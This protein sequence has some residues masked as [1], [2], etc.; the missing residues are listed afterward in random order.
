MSTVHGLKCDGCGLK[1]VFT[2]TRGEKIPS[3]SA[4]EKH[5]RNEGWN[6]PDK[7]GRHWCLDCRPERGRRQAKIRL[8][9][10]RN[11]ERGLNE[12]YGLGQCPGT[13]GC[14]CSRAGHPGVIAH[15]VS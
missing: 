4:L 12:G 3:K 1:L 5:A 6:A 8:A 13:P 2:R 14:Y 7:A 10:R 9:K 11:R 15:D